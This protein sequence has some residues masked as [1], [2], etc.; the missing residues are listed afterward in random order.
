MRD[1][2]KPQKNKA[3]DNGKGTTSHTR[4]AS[5]MV[6]RTPCVR[7]RCVTSRG[8]EMTLE[9]DA[10]RATT[11]TVQTDQPHKDEKGGS[12]AATEIQTNDN[13]ASNEKKGKQ[14][15]RRQHK[16]AATRKPRRS[17]RT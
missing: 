1:S 12:K 17:R 5:A 9:L 11:T 4:R 15:Q 2:P 6:K 10:S 3:K 8:A 14:R 13:N 16:I 7:A